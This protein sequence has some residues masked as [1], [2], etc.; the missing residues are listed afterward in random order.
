MSKDQF[1]QNYIDVN[2]NLNWDEYFLLTA[3]ITSFK[4]K[5]PSTKV[6]CVIVN[7]NKHQ[8]SAGYNGMVSG[9]DE[10]ELPWGKDK[11]APLEHQKYGYVVHA[12]ANAILHASKSL[13]GCT[14][15]VTLFPCNECA[16]LI[17][18]KKIKEIVYLSDKHKHQESTAISKKI[19]DLAGIKF[20]S[21][22][23]NENLLSKLSEHLNTLVASV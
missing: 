15:Y 5:D 20:R 4:S 13:E 2:T 18:S 23:I 21:V 1:P 3:M 10:T 19:F 16:K 22:E 8:V 17:A 12:E 7:H 14:A 11:T 6:G 9:I